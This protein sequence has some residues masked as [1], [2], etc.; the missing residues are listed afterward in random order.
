MRQ[1]DRQDVPEVTAAVTT[2]VNDIAE[3]HA[4]GGIVIGELVAVAEDGALH[5]NLPGMPPL[6]ARH[7]LI[8]LGGEHVGQSVVVA[9]QGA[10]VRSPIVLGLIWRPSPQSLAAQEP[11]VSEP[12]EDVS[13]DADELYVDGERIVIE[14]GKTLE[15]RCGDSALILSAD[16]RVELRGKYITSHA[17][18]TQ[19]ILGGSVNI[20]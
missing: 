15:L 4:P 19:R 18:A 12:S 11:I 5:L 20:N 6:T 8:P 7:A 10:G 13:E 2:S 17:T 16:G 3:Q 9:F 14:A 1:P